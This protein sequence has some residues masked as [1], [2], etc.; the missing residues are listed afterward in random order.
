MPGISGLGVNRFMINFVGSL[1]RF[2]ASLYR[3]RF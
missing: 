1:E 2:L 3:L